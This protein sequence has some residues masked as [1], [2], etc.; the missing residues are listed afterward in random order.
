MKADRAVL[1]HVLPFGVWVGIMSLPI[2]AVAWRYA[3]QTLVTAACLGW[4]RPWRYYPRCGVHLLPVAFLIGTS[5]CGLWILPE[6]AWMQRFPLVQD[7]YLKYAVFPLGMITGYEATSPYAPEQC[8]WPLALVRLAGSAVVIAAAEEFFWRGLVM[9]WL[10]G[11]DF[12]RVSPRAV[13]MT[14]LGLTA[15]LFAVEHDRWLVGMA[16]GWAYGLLYGRSGDIWAAVWAHM[17]TNFLL[18]LYVLATASYA[19]W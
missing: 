19:F 7:T 13:G 10:V 9:R 3:A 11:R 2:E 18:G 6:S 16:A 5:V 14:M 4:L 12:L 8:G 15:C 1:A 17:V